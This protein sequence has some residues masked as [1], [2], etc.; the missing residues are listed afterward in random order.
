MEGHVANG[1]A[2]A[3]ALTLISLVVSVIFITVR[4]RKD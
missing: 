1:T 2:M 4:E 3:V